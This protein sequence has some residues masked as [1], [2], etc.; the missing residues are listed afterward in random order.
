[1]TNTPAG[2]YLFEYISKYIAANS[3]LEML[4]ALTGS[5]CY[6]AAVILSRYKR[7]KIMLTLI[8]VGSICMTGAIYAEYTHRH[9]PKALIG[10]PSLD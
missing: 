10:P 6:V 1:M 7:D 4:F 5:L 9:P 2:F 8:I 3:S